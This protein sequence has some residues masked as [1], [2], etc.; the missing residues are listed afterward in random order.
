MYTITIQDYSYDGFVEYKMAYAGVAALR[1]TG[2]WD[3]EQ[4]N[5]GRW[6]YRNAGIWL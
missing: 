1:K 5:N 6:M 3:K 2:K 4:V